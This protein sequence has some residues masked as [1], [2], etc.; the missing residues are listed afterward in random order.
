MPAMSDQFTPTYLIDN[1]ANLDPQVLNK[2][3]LRGLVFPRVKGI[4]TQT[5]NPEWFTHA[6]KMQGLGAAGVKFYL[7]AENEG[8]ASFFA[9]AHYNRLDFE[10][11]IDLSTLDASKDLR[12][13]GMRTIDAERSQLLVVGNRLSDIAA[14]NNSGFQ[15][16]LVPEFGVKGLRKA[17]IQHPIESASHIVRGLPLLANNFPEELTPVHKTSTKD[18]SETQESP[19]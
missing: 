19:A 13:V 6:K 2:H 14:G 18:H 17:V 9:G 4:L 11:I 16:V 10:Q 8:E 3:N 12:R 1:V 5:S 15:T 7:L